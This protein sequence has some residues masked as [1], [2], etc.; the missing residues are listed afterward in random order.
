[1]T[2]DALTQLE[3][4]LNDWNAQRVTT[5]RLEAETQHAVDTI[6]RALAKSRGR[7]KRKVP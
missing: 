3:A 4:L 7:A 6:R 1:M 5:P 2:L